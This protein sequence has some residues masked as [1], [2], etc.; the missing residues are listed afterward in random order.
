MVDEFES[1]G[2]KS[3]HDLTGAESQH[4]PMLTLEDGKLG[5]PNIGR[6]FCEGLC[7]R[8]CCAEDHALTSREGG[9]R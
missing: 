9:D 2:R 8:V 3:Q 5:A 6:Q 1:K 4:V 7:V